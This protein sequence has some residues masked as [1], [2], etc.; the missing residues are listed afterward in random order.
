M[1]SHLHRRALV[2]ENILVYGWY[3]LPSAEGPDTKSLVSSPGKYEILTW[4]YGDPLN[5]S[6]ATREVGDQ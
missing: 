3:S 6:R 1:E 4:I 5:V 2:M